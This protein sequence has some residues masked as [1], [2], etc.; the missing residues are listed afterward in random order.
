MLLPLARSGTA[1]FYRKASA[2]RSESVQFQGR[3][4]TQPGG[5][6]GVIRV[7]IAGIPVHQD[8]QP[9]TMLIEPWNQR[10]EGLTVKFQLAAPMGVWPHRASE[11]AA[12]F[13]VEPFT[14]F[15][16]QAT[17]MVNCAGIK[18]DVRVVV[19]KSIL[20]CGCHTVLRGLLM[21]VASSL[22]RLRLR[23]QVFYNTGSGHSFT[24]CCN[25]AAN[26]HWRCNTMT[27]SSVPYLFLR[28]GTSRGPFFNRA[29]LPEDRDALSALLMAVVGA[30]HPLNIDGI[31]GGN[32]VTTKVVMISPSERDDADID[33]FFAQVAVNDRLVDYGPTCGNMLTGVAPAAIEM[34]MIQ[35]QGDTTRVRI[36][37]VNNGARIDAVVQTPGGQVR[38]DG[39]TAIDG[40]PGTAAPV[41]L[42]FLGVTGV[43]CGTMLPTGRAIDI[44]DGIEV[45]CVDVA[46]PIMIARASDFGLSGYESADEID[47][48]RDLYERLEA[49]R[50]EAG[51]RMGLGDV[52]EKVMPKLT[53]LAPPR[54][55]AVISARYLM[56]WNCHPTLAV[57]G[58]QCIAACAMTPG[59]VADGLA[60][61]PDTS[62]ATVRIEHPSGDIDVLLDY[63]LEDGEFSLNSAGLTRTTR[64]IARGELL[65]PPGI[66]D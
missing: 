30:G 54:G 43:N 3:W 56:P 32:A 6:L 23:E 12:N 41:Q 31:G 8:R 42:N 55:D 18:I 15:I 49:M 53:L 14:C 57:T 29:D 44:I 24:V 34:G 36:H 38:Y 1:F 11:D 58:A 33:Y 35:P 21:A 28:G 27:Q 64:L 13:H 9:V 26:T 60:R 50:I 4:L 51:E 19:I 65:V 22:P 40:V 39:D 7:V 63:T 10:I 66:L 61:C 37:A 5:V 52:R 47:G 17:G 46:M 2:V 62:P 16:A 59:T 20:W 48:N 45:S 25:T